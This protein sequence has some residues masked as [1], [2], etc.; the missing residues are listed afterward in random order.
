M[1]IWDAGKG[2]LSQYFQ[3]IIRVLLVVLAVAYVALEFMK[4]GQ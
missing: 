2:G 1:D 3:T 4:D